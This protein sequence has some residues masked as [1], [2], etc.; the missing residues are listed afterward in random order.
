MNTHLHKLSEKTKRVIT[1]A[2]I[3]VLGVSSVSAGLLITI[4]GGITSTG[5]NFI[6]Y[7]GNSGVTPTALDRLLA[8]TPNGITAPTTSGVS[9][10][11]SDGV[12]YPGGLLNILATGVDGATTGGASGIAVTGPN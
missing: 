1:L 4:G 5:G 10:I 8:F 9:L 3:V 6:T 7:D 12:T 2:L 11:G